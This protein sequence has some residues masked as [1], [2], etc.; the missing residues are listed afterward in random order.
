MYAMANIVPDTSISLFGMAYS[1]L[2]GFIQLY[3]SEGM[4]TLSTARRMQLW[5]DLRIQCLRLFNTLINAFEIDEA[6]TANNLNKVFAFFSLNFVAN[7]VIS[8]FIGSFISYVSN[9][10]GSHR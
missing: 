9:R 10:G 2:S 5:Y 1:I 8:I 6:G 4:S 3:D 7:G